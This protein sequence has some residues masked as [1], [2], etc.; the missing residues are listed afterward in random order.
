MASVGTLAVIGVLPSSTPFSA[1]AMQISCWVTSVVVGASVTV[2]ASV[3]VG[4]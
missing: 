2:G 4:A 1:S 3:V